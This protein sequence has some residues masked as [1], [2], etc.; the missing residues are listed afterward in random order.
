V[1][2]DRLL[3]GAGPLAIP[4]SEVDVRTTRSGGP[5]GQHA[6]TSETRV[7]VAFDIAGSPSLTDHQRA[8]LLERVGPVA[9]AVAEDTRS[10]ARNRELALER[11]AARLAAGLVRPRSRRPTRP[12]KGAV[13]RRLAA[14]KKTG[15][16]KRERRGHHDE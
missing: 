14:K 1:D 3:A 12:G 13:E 4:V 10:Q 2:D 9:R 6:N 15:D 8:L 11:L 16:R 5:G 7:E